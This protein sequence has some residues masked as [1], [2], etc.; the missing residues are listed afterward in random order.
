MKLGSSLLF[1]ALT[2]GVAVVALSSARL[3]LEWPAETTL[4]A[5]AWF[6]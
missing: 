6:V 4:D 1:L 5:D 2:A 3:D